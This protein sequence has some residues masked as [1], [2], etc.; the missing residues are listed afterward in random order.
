MFDA[1]FVQRFERKFEK[2]EGCWLWRASLAGKGYGQIKLPKQRRQEYAHRVS[3]LIYRGEITAG[4]FVCHT[5]DIPRCVNPDHLFLG[6]AK[7][8]LQDMKQKGRST[9]GVRNARA[10][11]TEEEVRQ[12]RVCLAAGMTQMQI[13]SAFKLCQVQV[14][15][16]HT[17][18]R[19]AHIL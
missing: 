6:T 19:W 18:K 10:K 2:T 3:Y 11:L 4:W 8:N 12:I 5:C 7:D 13:A 9:S 16:I 17:R 14:S 1:D 15:R